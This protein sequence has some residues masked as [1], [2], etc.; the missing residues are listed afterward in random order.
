MTFEPRLAI[1]RGYAVNRRQSHITRPTLLPALSMLSGRIPLSSKSDVGP[2]CTTRES[3][4]TTQDELLHVCGLTEVAG[5]LLTCKIHLRSSEILTGL[6]RQH[7]CQ[8]AI[9]TLLTYDTLIGLAWGISTLSVLSTFITAKT[10]C[11]SQLMPL[12]DSSK[13]LR[14]PAVFTQCHIVRS[15]SMGIEMGIQA[16][17]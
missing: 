17:R 11:M 3:S 1:I 8:L 6:G 2:T 9:S 16:P 14:S 7:I 10:L 12:P 13:W 5:S 4:G 15:T